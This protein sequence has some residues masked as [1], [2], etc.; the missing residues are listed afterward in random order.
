MSEP[1]LNVK[2]QF[3]TVNSKNRL[4]QTP[5]QHPDMLHFDPFPKVGEEVRVYTPV[6]GQLSVDG[7][8][9]FARIGTG[10][11][12]GSNSYRFTLEFLQ[13]KRWPGLE[14]FSSTAIP[15]QYLKI[16]HNFSFR[17]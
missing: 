11:G 6:N 9:G 8:G 14:K 5:K 13:N 7:S 2:Q 12:G 15:I 10:G 16:P 4:N 3:S 1:R 17:L